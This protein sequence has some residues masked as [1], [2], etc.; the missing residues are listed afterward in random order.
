LARTGGTRA[1]K[2]RPASSQATVR[3]R[4]SA[5]RRMI[6]TYPVARPVLPGG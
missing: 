2:T 6:I 3:R 5:G 1:Y 4:F